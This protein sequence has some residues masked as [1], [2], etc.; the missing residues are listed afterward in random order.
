MSMP[1]TASWAD[2]RMATSVEAASPPGRGA[3]F[4]DRDG[5][6]IHDR[7]YLS[8]PAGVE[9][10]PGAGPAIA[11]LNRASIPV[12]LVT[13]Q[14]GIGRGYFTEEAFFSTQ[15][16]LAELLGQHGARLDGVYHCPHAPDSQPPCACR[17]PAAGLF[18][19]AAADLGVDPAASFF[20]G[21][22]AR[23]ILPV[24]ELGGVPMLV[25]PDGNPPDEPLPEQTVV[26]RGL[27]EA[28]GRVLAA[29]HAD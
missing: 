6:V 13:N 8:D 3:V 29:V 23:D 1:A 9:L 5:T 28:V 20:I 18:R 27:D 4:L 17:K 24:V 26:V 12:I 21:D 2:K 14:S 22:R 10:M 11:R 25:Q 15:R 7:E 19:Q 16:R